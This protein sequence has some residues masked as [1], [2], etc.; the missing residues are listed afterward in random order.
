VVLFG[1]GES[2]HRQRGLL[3]PAGNF[4]CIRHSPV[5]CTPVSS[6]L[7]SGPSSL[8]PKTA[9]R[10]PLR[11]LVEDMPPDRRPQ[12]LFMEPSVFFRCLLVAGFRSVPSRLFLVSSGFLIS[13]CMLSRFALSTSRLYSSFPVQGFHR[14][15]PFTCLLGPPSPPSLGLN[16][17]V[18]NVEAG[19]V[20]SGEPFFHFPLRM[21]F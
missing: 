19:P 7:M 18:T 9:K 16:G 2:P 15:S 13:L 5:P 12:T 6:L 21:P 3:P 10:W 1:T 8:P 17:A 4:K 20:F 14:Y 11:N